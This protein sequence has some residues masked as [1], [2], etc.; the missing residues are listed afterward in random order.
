M[1]SEGG[2]LNASPLLSGLFGSLQQAAVN[3]LPTQDL[4]TQLRVN[5][6]TWQWQTTGQGELPS[7]EVLEQQGRSILSEQGVGIQQVNTYRALANQWASA[8]DA[9]HAGDPASQVN[10]EQ[11]FT[12]PWAQTTSDAVP[13]RYRVRVNW[14][15]TPTSGDPYSTWGAYEASDP[16]TSIQ[17]VLDQAGSLVGKKPTSNVPLGS[18]VT[19]VSDYELEQI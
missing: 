17:D 5:A 14:E 18:Q 8:K 1:A 15:V 6:A 11:I 16:L 10:G 2:W 13:S 3:H 7:Q 12:P 9:L 4:W 19:G